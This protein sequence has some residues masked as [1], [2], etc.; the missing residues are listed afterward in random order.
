MAAP[1][2]YTTASNLGVIQEG[3]FYQFGLDARDPAGGTIEYSIVSGKLPDGIELANNGLLFGNPRKVV[4]GVPVEVNRD[5]TSK[6]SIRAKDS[7]GIVNDKTFQLIVTG[8]DIPTWESTQFLGNYIDFQYINKQILVNDSD[9]EDTLTYELLS[10]SLPTGTELTNDGYIRGFI[11]P[12]LVQGSSNVGSFDTSAFDTELFDFGQG[13]GSYSKMHHFVVRASDGKAFIVKEFSIYVFGAFDLKADNDTITADKDDLL[14]QADTSSQYG[15]IIRHADSNIGTFLHDNMFSFKV[16]A[17]DYS[18]AGITYSIYAGDAAWDQ[19]GYDTELFDAIEGEMPEGLTIDPSTGWIHGKLP[20][21]NQVIKEYSFIVKAA[22]TSDPDNFYDTHQFTMKLITNKDL[23]I[24]WN[25]PKDLGILQ[26]G[27]ASTLFVNATSKNNTAL[28]YELQP[29]SKLPQGLKLNST[30]ELEGRASFK[31]F[32]LDSG[33]TKLD[34]VQ[35]SAT[36]T[37]DGTYTFSIK[38]R[39]NTGTLFNTRTFSV[40]VKNEYSAPYEDLYI[41]LLPSQVDR[42]IWKDVIYNRQDIP[43]ED[44]YRATDIYFGRQEHPRMLFLPG[45]PAN[46][47]SKYFESVYKN[48]HDINLRF[49]DFKYAK[50][51]DNNNNHIYD[52]VYVDILDKFDPPAGTVLNTANLEIKYSSINN[53]ITVDESAHIENTNLRASAN[54][55]KVLYPASLSRMKKRVEDKLGIQD[56]RTLPRWMTSVQDDGTVLGF[57]SACVIAYLKPGAGKRILYYLDINKN[58]NL[59]KIN[60]TVDRYVL[61]AY[62][63]KNYDKDSTPKAWLVGAETTFDSTNTSL[64]GKNTRFFPNI[65][66]KRTDITDGNNYIKF[67]RNEI[68]DLP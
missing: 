52:V 13:V 65:D 54:N 4:Q 68:I 67:P 21:L 46:T 41:D 66:T 33:T 62:F 34:V 19:A 15:P 53:P 39:D 29:N 32:Q 27:A 63:S 48:H 55:N 3:Q 45:L 60:F 28:V 20:F 7:T 18:G 59:N 58:I 43:D 23:D 30:G 12:Q 31:T 36:T 26:T 17:I 61:D 24:T 16:D 8:Q 5:V 2:W 49:G 25:T 40:V 50:A 1:V 38:A 37:V 22:R 35:N 42:N 14:I 10:G 9:T 57:T 11:Q 56:S 44:L 47:L 6:F 51:T 64:D